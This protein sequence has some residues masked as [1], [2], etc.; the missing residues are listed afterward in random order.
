M[1]WVNSKLV[2]AV[3]PQLYCY[4]HVQTIPSG[5]G[6]ATHSNLISFPL[7]CK[8]IRRAGEQSKQT[9]RISESEGQGAVGKSLLLM[10]QKTKKAQ[11]S[12]QE[13]LHLI[14]SVCCSCLIA[15]CVFSCRALVSLYFMECA[16]L[17]HVQTNTLAN[18]VTEAS[19]E[20]VTSW[21]LKSASAARG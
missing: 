1:Q 10:E 21:L 12:K 20:Q 9:E 15:F 2:K 18:R 7:W 17:V 16:S 14:G 4:C 13:M 8:A 6:S 5:T 19:V 3:K 11:L